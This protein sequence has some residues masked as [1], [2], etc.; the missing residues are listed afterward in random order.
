M[1]KDIPIYLIA[2]FLESGKTSMIKDL[3]NDPEFTDN[4]KTLLITCEEGEEELA[5]DL[6]EATK[7]IEYVLESK[8]ELTF[9]YLQKLNRAERPDRVIVE[10][11][12][13]W[14]VEEFMSLKLPPRWGLAQTITTVNAET[15]ELYMANMRQ[16]MMDQLK[17]SDLVL[18]NRCNDETPVKTHWRNMRM[19]NRAAMVIFEKPDGSMITVDGEDM[20][21]YDVHA[22]VIK[23]ED[24]DFGLWF[25]D[26]LDNPERYD[27]KT[28]QFTGQVYRDDKMPAGFFIPGRYIMNCCSADMQFAGYLCKSKVASQLKKESWVSVTAKVLIRYMD[29]YQ[30]EAPVLIATKMDPGKQ[31]EKE[32]VLPY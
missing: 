26:A 9:E 15:A 4:E 3:L 14:P 31:P 12:G 2:G 17:F 5:K 25:S 6:K 22:D 11:N 32:Y 7:T 29:F 18:F 28:V 20:L 30:R 1:P 19:I 21:P 23:I 13:T 10:Y 24:D 16:I 8:D 27:G